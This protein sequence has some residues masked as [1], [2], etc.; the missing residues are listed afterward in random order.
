MKK[1]ELCDYEGSSGMIHGVHTVCN[2]CMWDV[3]K[4]SVSAGMRFNKRV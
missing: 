1:C 4:F 2:A 3:V